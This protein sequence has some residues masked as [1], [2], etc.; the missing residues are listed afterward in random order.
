MMENMMPL[1]MMS[2][3]GG[4]SGDGTAQGEAGD[5]SGGGMMRMMMQMMMPELFTE[6]IV[7]LWSDAVALGTVKDRGLLR[8]GQIDIMLMP[9]S[10][11][12]PKA[13]LRIV[14]GNGVI[15][16][17]P[18]EFAKLQAFFTDLKNR[19]VTVYWPGEKDGE[20]LSVVDAW[21]KAQNME[22]DLDSKRLITSMMK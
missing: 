18:D 2:Q 17:R 10:M 4:G 9:P 21:A 11:N 5:A 13:S 3:L 16:V 12:S 19:V 6:D 1:M 8:G 20:E 15:S 14:C 7:P 22:D